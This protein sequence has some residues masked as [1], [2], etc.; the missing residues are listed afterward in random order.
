VRVG[1]CPEPGWESAQ[2]DELAAGPLAANVFAA[3]LD[4]L[5]ARQFL[6]PPKSCPKPQAGEE[7]DAKDRGGGRCQALKNSSDLTVLSVQRPKNSD[8]HD[9]QDAADDRECGPP[10]PMWFFREA[11]GNGKETER[12]CRDGYEGEDDMDYPVKRRRHWHGTLGIAWGRVLREEPINNQSQPLKAPKNGI[13]DRAR[14]AF[15][16][17]APGEGRPDGDDTKTTKLTCCTHPPGPRLSA[18]IGCCQAL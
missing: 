14:A 4:S 11:P 7:H 3:R 6:K 5:F 9:G 12:H 16:E 17:D 8:K 10:A 15:Q 18:L 1:L 13:P 2:A